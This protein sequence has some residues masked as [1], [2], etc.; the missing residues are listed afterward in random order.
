MNTIATPMQYLDKAMNQLHDLGLL[1]EGERQEAPIIALL[2]QI[3]D[4]D[5][6]RV[7]AIARTL[8]Q[9]SLFNEV[10][11]E[12]VQAMEIGERY[13]EIT[14]AFNSIRDDAK[15]MVEQAEDGKIDTF[16]RLGNIW[17][18]VS[19]GDIA[20]RFDKIKETYLEVTASTHD[21]IQREQKILQAYQDFRG[22]LKQSEVL[23]LEVLKTAEGKLDAAKADVKGAMKMI[24]T[25]QG[26]EVAE[27]AKLE[28]ARDEKVRLLQNEEKRYQIAKDLSDNLTIS[29]N[30]SEVVMARLIQTTNAKERVYAQAVS[31]FSTNEVVL[32]ALTASF[33]GMFG[34]HESTRTVEAMKEGVSQS[35]EVLADIG[36]KVQEAAVKAGYGPTVRADAV[37]KLVDSVV[38]WQSRSHEIIEEMRRQSTANAREIRNAVEESKR[39]LARLAEAGKGVAVAAQ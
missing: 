23:A 1:S 6:A 20:T 3:S 38:N 14:H 10:V 15:S 36:G 26:E 29:Y 18:K 2:N 21:Q 27:R 32:T 11:R 37:K 9:A 12:Q 30:T 35:L 8:N 16:E 24:E 5:Q 25:Y 17:M 31:F 7:T 13:E 33:T 19:R 39:K 34:L 22:A 4:L 28:L